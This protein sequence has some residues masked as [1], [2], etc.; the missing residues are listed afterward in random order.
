M[1]CERCD[2][3]HRPARSGRL[4][5]ADSAGTIRRV[6]GNRKAPLSVERVVRHFIGACGLIALAVIGPCASLASALSCAEHPDGSPQAI[7]AGTERLSGGDRFFDQYDYAVIGTVTEVQTVGAEP[8]YGATTVKVD[9]EGVLGESSAPEQIDISSPDP[10]W[11]NGYP[12][13]RG[14]TYFIPVQAEGPE[15]QP[16][17]SFLC[18][19]ISEVDVGVATELRQ[20]AE[21]AGV[22]FST[23]DDAAPAKTSEGS[24]LAASDP[25]A[26][27]DMTAPIVAAVL[28]VAMAVIVLSVRSRYRLRSAD[29]P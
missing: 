15:G 6:F 20:L 18:D 19:P 4:R 23:P 21:G 14:T 1:R 10:G 8:N 12:Y 25:G 27:F 28:T 7:A 16:N 22:A 24:D 11:L 29:V 17:Y 13:E 5:L 3:A 2:Q 9:V 26:S